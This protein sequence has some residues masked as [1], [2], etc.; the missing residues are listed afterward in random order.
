M[1]LIKTYEN[2]FTL[3]GDLF[4]NG[5]TIRMGNARF[6][7]TDSHNIYYGYNKIILPNLTDKDVEIR[8]NSPK[9][10]DCSDLEVLH[11]FLKK[12]LKEISI[13]Y[14]E[15]PNIPEEKRFDFSKYLS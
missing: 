14:G 3:L 8:G 1:K 15:H 11:K 4:R 7:C 10:L 6:W 5:L 13:F 2:C 12:V 9:Y